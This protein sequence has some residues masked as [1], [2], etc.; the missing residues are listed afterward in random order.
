M[1]AGTIKIVGTGLIGTSLGL[2]LARHGIKAQ[3]SDSS[4]ANL[5]LAI[6]YGAGVEQSSEPDLVVVCVPP[7]ITA[8]VVAKELKQH[9]TAIVTD[10]ASVKS[11][12]YSEV[13]KLSGPDAKRYIGS[14]PMA[15]REKGGPG[16]ARAD[17]FFARPW[18]LTPGESSEESAVEL[19]KDLALQIG[20][21][22]IVMSVAEH[23][24]A[25]ALVSHLPQ[26]VASSLAARLVE[27]EESQ[28]NLTGQGLRDTSRIAA[29]DPT[30]WLQILSQN[31]DAISPLLSKLRQDIEVLEKAFLNLSEAGALAKIHS[32]LERGNSGIAKIP[33]KHG[34]KFVDYQ[35]LTI[36]IDDSPGALASLLTF[37]GDVGVNIEDLKLEHSPGAPIGLVE[38]QVL[39]E[40]ADL[41]AKQLTENGWRIV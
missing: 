29:S 23:D 27:G 32:L 10:T 22:P 5:R 11:E 37:I 17:L 26:L 24:E 30:L 38:I 15:G 8:E 9:P 40:S 39:P 3:L 1:K 34:G 20:A 13:K 21:L 7:D 4:K 28:L 33:G 12:I 36:V 19:I 35:Q 14:H 25:V 31:A 6:E 41:L 18:V 16:S 2:S